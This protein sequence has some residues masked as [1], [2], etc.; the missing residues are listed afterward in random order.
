LLSF[1][2]A[3]VWQL[4]HTFVVIALVLFYSPQEERLSEIASET[5][6]NLDLSLKLAFADSPVAYGGP[7]MTEEYSILHGWGEVEGSK[8][9]ANGV[10]IGGSEE[11]MNE[12][13]INRFD[14]ANA[15]FVKGHAAWVPGKLSREIKKGVWYSMG[16]TYAEIAK[17]HGN[18]GDKR[19]MP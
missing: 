7:V 4:I 10:Y 8:K 11:L 18:R 6:S 12:V 14:P 3:I 19:L 1:L 5:D 13:R 16:G 9:L 2:V 17:T 15:L